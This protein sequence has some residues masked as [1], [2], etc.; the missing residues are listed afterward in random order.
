MA[1]DMDPPT[2][3]DDEARHVQA[4]VRA[5]CLEAIAVGNL[6]PG[7]EL[8]LISALD[9]GTVPWG[10]V[11]I[12]LKEK[13][14]LP[15]EDKGIDSMAL[16][17]T[18]AVQAKDYSNGTVPLN[19]LTNFHFMVKADHSPLKNWVKRLVVATSD[20]TELPRHWQQFSG[21]IH[22]KYS[23]EEIDTWRRKAQLER[24]MEDELP[25]RMKHDLPRWPHQLE[26][27]RCCRNFVKN[28]YSKDFF[29]QMA[30]GS[31]KSLVMTDLI[32]DMGS[33]KRSCIIV[34]KLDLMEQM[35]Q[36]LETTLTARIARVGTGYPADLSADVFVCVRNS[37]WQLSNLTFDLLLLDEA[38]H[39]EPLQMGEVEDNLQSSGVHARQ[40]LTLN[41]SKR[42][43]FTATLRR[44]EPD[45]DFGLRPAIQAGV[46]KDYSVM[47]PVLTAGDPRPSLA[48]LIQDLPMARKI[49]AFCNTVHEAK[50]FTRM[51]SEVGIAAEH[52]NGKTASGRRQEVLRRFQSSNRLGGVRVLVTVDVLSEGVDLPAADT[53]LFVAPRQGVRLQQCVGRVLRNHSEKVDA[54]VIAPAI[55][56]SN[57]ALAEDAELGRLLSEM[58]RADPVFK[59]SL[60]DG[61]SACGRV[62]PAAGA[63]V[64]LPTLED[65]AKMLRIRVFP[66][67][68][69]WCE[70]LDG[71]ELGFEELRAYKD[72]HGD[73]LVPRR[74]QTATGCKL[75]GWVNKQRVAKR[76]G[77]LN[78]EQVDR[79][80]ELDFAWDVFSG[81][82]GE[83]FQEL[84]AYK[85]EHGDTLVPRRHQTATGYNL[86][87]WVDRQRV[88]KRKGRLNQEQ[89]DRLE[90][91][92][93]AWDVFSGLWGEA[94]QELQAY[95]DEHGDTL[96]PR[97]HQ[98]ATGYNLGGWVNKQRVAKR[99]GRLN[100]EQVDR[101]E[102]LGFVW[103]VFSGLSWGE[104]FQELQAYKD[105][106]GDTLVPCDHQTATG[107]NLGRW[108]DRQRVAKRK[109]RLN[110]E[111]VDRLEE[112]DFAWDVLSGL[113]GEAF[114]ELQAYKDDHG[115]T[116]VPRRHQTATGYNLGGWVNKQRVAKRKGRLNQEQVDR[117][118]E[119]D[120]AWD[121]FSGLWGEAFQELQAYKDE[122]GDTLVPRRHQTATGY[123]LGGWVNKQRVAKRKG[124]L[125][126]EQVDRLEELGF[127]WD[128]FSGL[129][130]GEAF[131]ELQ[132]YKDE[133][134][135]TL[136]PCDHQTATGYNLGRWVNRQRVAKRKGRLN[137]EQVDR[138]EELDFVWD[139]SG[140]RLSKICR[141]TK[142]CHGPTMVFEF[143][144][145]PIDGHRHNLYVDEII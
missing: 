77:R 109:G 84:Q 92:D 102:E 91:L 12:K 122:H 49:L 90:E 4:V 54:L 55:Q 129:S 138:L 59:A 21:S 8:E 64:S 50:N 100:Q 24:P 143:E 113:W 38:H 9:L 81:L 65:A 117:L 19:R 144:C 118:E 71:W 141:C 51:L 110:Q 104:A 69:R 120:F 85:D 115:D 136:V 22:R 125:N 23:A 128:V 67:S 37:A 94:F 46:I 114:Q 88:A 47:V 7:R 87:G 75:G 15:F 52:Y 127:V 25:Q 116:L 11:P 60:A 96:V 89:V 34:P 140:M 3:S 130:W 111:Q 139:A 98:T 16:N 112:L 95:K 31:G 28:D 108:V 30:T 10:L 72:E 1:K 78:Q 42:I 5:K 73:T 68:L 61:A 83:A 43:F 103:D 131:Q 80:E 137:Q 101:L 66:N 62:V 35:A 93:F 40:V 53:C 13:L 134:G 70:G 86:G 36:L 18:V 29:V 27:L 121:V 106:H 57:G 145:S 119:L 126:Q 76:T 142:T 44:N 99:K 2:L 123:N 20:Q 124:R 132:A 105:E 17:L 135:D 58:A 39:Y 56:H 33:N 74:H 14:G 79:L 63:S 41:T 107:Y 97:R 48:Q 133:H 32:A 45:F 26:C 6:P 82:W